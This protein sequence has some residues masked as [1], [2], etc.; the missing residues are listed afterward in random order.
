MAAGRATNNLQMY[1]VNE[2]AIHMVKILVLTCAI[3]KVKECFIM[4]YAAIRVLVHFAQE[5]KDS[6][7]GSSRD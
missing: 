6:F 2:V 7:E 5:E 3:H 4:M 1:A